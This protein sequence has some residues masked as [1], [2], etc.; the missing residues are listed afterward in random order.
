MATSPIASATVNVNIQDTLGNQVSI[1]SVVSGADG[2]FSKLWQVTEADYKRFASVIASSQRSGYFEGIGSAQL[3]SFQSA[4]NNG[5]Q[6]NISMQNFANANFYI[7]P[8]SIV[9]TH[10]G[11]TFPITVT[12]PD[13]NWFIEHS[14]Q[15]ITYSRVGSTLNVTVP[16]GE[17]STTFSNLILVWASGGQGT[18]RAI[19]EISRKSGLNPVKNILYSGYVKESDGTPVEDAVIDLAF[20]YSDTT[21]NAYVITRTDVNG[22]YSYTRPC[23]EDEWTTL[24]DIGAAASK[25]GFITNSTWIIPAHIPFDTITDIGLNFADIVLTDQTEFSIS[26]DVPTVAAHVANTLSIAVTCPDNTWTIPTDGYPSWATVVRISDTMINITITENTTVDNRTINVPVT[27]QDQTRTATFIQQA[28]YDIRFELSKYN[29]TFGPGGGVDYFDVLYDGS[30]TVW[31]YQPESSNNIYTYQ[32]GNRVYIEATS[33]DNR[34]KGDGAIMV[35]RT[36]PGSYKSLR[37]VYSRVNYPPYGGN[38]SHCIYTNTQGQQTSE[39]FNSTN[40][41][42]TL[43][44]S[45]GGPSTS[46]IINGRSIPYNTITDLFFGASYV[47]ITSIGNTNQQTTGSYFSNYT[48]LKTLDFNG[49]SYLNYIGSYVAHNCPNLNRISILSATNITGGDTSIVAL[50]FEGVGANGYLVFGPSQRPY[51]L[52]ILNNRIGDNLRNA[53]WKVI[54]SL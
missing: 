34:V 10:D 23:S 24:S 25:V 21:P 46:V 14:D 19:C 12:A 37:F 3:P 22:Y 45:G 18:K 13:D 44:N 50:P 48:S 17:T 38:D 16:A 1:G 9:A 42:F 41:P 49:L 11:G 32:D 2:N 54:P 26:P 28:P 35:I 20:I 15:R 39:A 33:Y 36:S 29:T 5:I 8:T 52:A 40:T 31:S 7:N 47:N 53:G 43:F 30:S 27:W 6:L 4:I 51:G